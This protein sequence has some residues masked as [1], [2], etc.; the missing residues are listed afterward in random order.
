VSRPPFVVL[1]VC[2][3]NICRSPMAER[4]LAK[5]VAD[6]LG[7]GAEAYVHSESAGTSGWHVGER[8]YP[9]ASHELKR[10][11]ATDAGFRARRLTGAHIDTADLILTATAEQLE[12]VNDLRPDAFERAFALREFGRL[13]RGVTDT[14]PVPI[15]TRATDPDA[16]F[17]RANALVVA[18]DVAR[19]GSGPTWRDD[20]EDPWGREP[21]FFA[22]TA[23]E[24]EAALR[25]FVERLLPDQSG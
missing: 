14:T 11:G 13:I 7:D 1:H 19:N 3:G 17:V 23:D 5:L 10:R 16:I 6:R 21:A 24:I 18:A 20:L 2:L 9:P 25:P 4:L 8:M 22:K 12:V 15:V